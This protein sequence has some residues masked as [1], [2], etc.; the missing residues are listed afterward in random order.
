MYANFGL[1]KNINKIKLKNE[2]IKHFFKQIESTR[3]NI[4]PQTVLGEKQFL[5]NIE[6]KFYE[7]NGT[8]KV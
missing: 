3:Q 1:V 8:I 4:T 2:N 5:K 6:E 7:S